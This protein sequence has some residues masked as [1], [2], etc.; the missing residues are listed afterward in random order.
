M[1]GSELPDKHILR[2]DWTGSLDP[3]SEQVMLFGHQGM[4]HLLAWN[5][6][7]WRLL[8]PHPTKINMSPKQ[9]HLPTINFQGLL[10]LVFGEV[11]CIH[12]T[13]FLYPG[14]AISVQGGPLPVMNRRMR[15]MA[16][17]NGPINWFH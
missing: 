7:T 9:I 14:Q 13:D 11:I 8:L 5:H 12:Y 10:L 15:L 2:M 3:P 16:P 6:E 4:N 17:T 1:E